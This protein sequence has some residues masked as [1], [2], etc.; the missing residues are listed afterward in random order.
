[1]ATTIGI[2]NNDPMDSSEWVLSGLAY[3]LKQVVFGIQQLIQDGGEKSNQKRGET[4]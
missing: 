2:N 4:L 1:M 3:W